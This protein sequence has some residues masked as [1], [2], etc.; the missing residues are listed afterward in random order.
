MKTL[1]KITIDYLSAD[2]AEV[3]TVVLKIIATG[4][5]AAMH[6]ALASQYDFKHPIRIICE[7]VFETDEAQT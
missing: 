7:L 2:S 4:M 6:H 5:P 3:R 1:Y